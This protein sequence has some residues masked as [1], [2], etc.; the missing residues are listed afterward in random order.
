MSDDHKSVDFSKWAVVGFKDDTGL[1]RMSRDIQKVLGVTKH[2]VSPSERMPTS[3]IQSPR[4][5]LMGPGLNQETLRKQMDG[6]EG[7]I[8]LERLH[9]NELLLPTA[10][11]LGLKVVC[12]PM[13][14][15][16]RGTDP[17]WRDADLFLC[18]N[19]KSEEVL[20]SYGF[21]NTVQMAWPL[22]LDL[23]PVR[24]IQGNAQTFIHNAGL[25]DHDDR[26]GT[27]SV[28]KA[29]GKVR[30]KDLRL[31]LRLQQEAPFSVNDPRVD[32]RIGNLQNPA[33]LYKEGDAA[34]QPSRMEGLGFMVLEPVCCGLPVITT[35]AEP[36]NEYVQQ[37]EMRARPSLIKRK[38][39]AWKAASIK[40]AYLTS[41]SV[42]SL[43]R[44]IQWCSKNDLSRISE[45]NRN[46]GWTRHASQQMAR[47]WGVTLNHLLE[48]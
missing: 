17:E 32:V 47:Q 41:P 3:E 39:F 10:K 35:D 5:F 46:Y 8:C 21:K 45:E 4:E 43:A 37:P 12:V 30:N 20:H 28:V 19:R 9:W 24:T 1:G 29:F 40:H 22:N 14:E 33:D 15:W 7:I 13:W 42:S 18:P 2:L 23:L 27:Q 31:I 36:M 34:I 16:F 11:Q 25:I 44:V 6:L 38:S 48:N 26:K